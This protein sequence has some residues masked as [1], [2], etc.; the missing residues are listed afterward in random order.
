MSRVRTWLAPAV[1]LSRVAL[2][3]SVLAVFVLYDMAYLVND[4]VPHG[5][6]PAE[7][8]QPLLLRRVLDLPVPSPG[9]VRT[10]QVVL[11]VAALLVALG[12]LPRLAGWVLALGFLDWV[13]IGMSYA[14][15][16]HDHFALVVAL[17][18]LP[19]AGAARLRDLR[20]G[21]AAGFALRTV[22][23]ACVATY[24]LSAVA[25]MRFGGWDWATGATFAWAMSR[26]GT[27]LGD[28][29][30][31]APWLLRAG[32]WGVLLME[33]LTPA[34]LFVRTRWQ[35]IGAGTL[36]SFHLLTWLTTRIHFLPLIVCLAAFVPVERLLPSAGAPALPSRGSGAGRPGGRQQPAGLAE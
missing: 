27:Q 16:D 11:V 14:K 21:A 25:K 18:A 30:A 8:Y 34:L 3:R 28:V 33:T 1:P 24:F 6:V 2:L 36:V 35:A 20:A 19:T 12:R 15:I 4:V 17:F 13:S 10:L 26:R 9:Y 31:E 23:V 32:Q 5:Y 29:L 7:F 22:Q